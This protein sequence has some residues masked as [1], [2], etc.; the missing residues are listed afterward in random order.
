[1]KNEII[2]YSN[3]YH[4]YMQRL[5][6]IILKLGSKCRDNQLSLCINFNELGNSKERSKQPSSTYSFP[7]TQLDGC[8]LA[9]KTALLDK[10]HQLTYFI[11][12]VEPSLLPMCCSVLFHLLEVKYS[13]DY[14]ERRTK[15]LNSSKNANM[16]HF[17]KKR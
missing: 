14:F 6:V 12:V 7:T 5:I 3:T 11:A 4:I 17:I 13:V 2:L 10:Y 1:M 8:I 15:S 9:S 16:Q